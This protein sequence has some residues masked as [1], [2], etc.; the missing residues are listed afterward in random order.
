M[1]RFW[2]NVLFTMLEGTCSRMQVAKCLLVLILN[3]VNTNSV[4]R[5]LKLTT[6]HRIKKLVTNSTFCSDLDIKLVF[7]LETTCLITTCKSNVL[8]SLGHRHLV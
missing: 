4:S 1:Q 5:S 8:L 7:T 3:R 6:V 2:L